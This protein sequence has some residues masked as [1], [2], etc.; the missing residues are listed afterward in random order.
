MMRYGHEQNGRRFALR[1]LKAVA[2]G[3]TTCPRC[4]GLRQIVNTGEGDLLIDCPT[5][6]GIGAVTYE[7][8]PAAQVE[9][10]SAE[11][12]G[13]QQTGDGDHDRDDEPTD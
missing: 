13:L 7:E 9:A 3:F 12:Q 1:I 5:C 8:Y 11:R 10:W 4:D 2:Y 6:K